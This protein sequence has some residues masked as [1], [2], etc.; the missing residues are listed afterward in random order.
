MTGV[1]TENRE[2]IPKHHGTMTSSVSNQIELKILASLSPLPLNKRNAHKTQYVSVEMKKGGGTRKVNDHTEL[3]MNHHFSHTKKHDI[4]RRDNDE[5][6]HRL[7]PFLFNIHNRS[8][9]SPYKQRTLN[10]IEYV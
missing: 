7:F 2:A 3:K 5:Q 8:L 4:Q 9:D 1:K 10:I 6:C